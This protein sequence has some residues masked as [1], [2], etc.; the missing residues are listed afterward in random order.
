[1]VA[2]KVVADN[3]VLSNFALSGAQA[4]MLDLFQNLM[5][6]KHVIDE[7]DFGVQRGILPQ[8]SWDQIIRVGPFSQDEQ[9]TFDNL[10]RKVDIGEASCLSVAFHRKWKIL[11]DDLDARK[12]ARQLGI[13]VSGT[14]GVLVLAVSRKQLLL[15]EGNRILE[16]MIAKG[17]YAPYTR[18][19]SLLPH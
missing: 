9:R 13:P 15:D 6:T 12:T 14:I 8:D 7:Y 5:T 1:M 3:T 16:I 4:V 10:C 17:Y 18:L 11:T 2:A 19:D